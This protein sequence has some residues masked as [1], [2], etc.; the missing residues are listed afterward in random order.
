[1]Y[2]KYLRVDGTITGWIPQPESATDREVL[3]LAPLARR[4]EPGETLAH[5]RYGLLTS[6]ACSTLANDDQFGDWDGPSFIGQF[7]RQ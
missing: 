5:V 7:V 6:I 1:M 3:S 4:Y 2:K